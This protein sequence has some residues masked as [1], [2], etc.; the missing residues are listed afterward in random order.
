MKRKFNLNHIKKN[1]SYSIL[2]I[3]ESFGKHKN[4]IYNWI[5]DGLKT[6]GNQKPILIHGSDLKE[7][8]HKKYHTKKSIRQSE[9][10][11]FCCKCQKYQKPF[12]NL[13]DVFLYTKNRGNLQ[14]I[15]E[16]CDTKIYQTFGVRK[17]G[18]IEKTFDVVKV[19][20]PHLIECL[21]STSNCD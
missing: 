9:N 8:L 10:E 15:C 14:G 4:T 16:V 5:D 6:L 20:N 3:C 7:Y 1:Y 2:E 11:I 17:L 12:G 21:N 13:I 19:H 18:L